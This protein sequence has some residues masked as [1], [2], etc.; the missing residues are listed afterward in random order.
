M[1]ELSTVPTAIQTELPPAPE[2]EPTLQEL[3]DTFHA[4]QNNEPVDR[5]V[6]TT[7]GQKLDAYAEYAT[8]EQ[9]NRAVKRYRGPAKRDEQ[10]NVILDEAGNEVRTNIPQIYAKLIRNAAGAAENG[11]TTQEDWAKAALGNDIQ[12]INLSQART[13][14]RA[15]IVEQAFKA[16]EMHVADANEK[17]EVNA[18]DKTDITEEQHGRT[19]TEQ[20][21][22][23]ALG[24]IKGTSPSPEKLSAAIGNLSDKEKQT[25][26]KKL[27]SELE[28]QINVGGQT[29]FNKAVSSAKAIDE[30]L[31]A[32]ASRFVPPNVRKLYVNAALKVIDSLGM[33]GQIIL[34]NSTS[35][36]LRTNRE[37]AARNIER[38]SNTTSTD[39]EHERASRTLQLRRIGKVAAANAVAVPTR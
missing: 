37:Q 6:L 31:A 25:V 12:N 8:D 34:Q 3:R 18:E 22:D 32:H 20:P 19:E 2:P 4:L 1:S 11:A 38:L 14:I 5:A 33:N 15:L 13:F 36:L 9:G 7:L 27:S 35:Q 17:P 39:A 23:K 21:L 30:Y 16:K 10:G 29:D 28:E 24:L 26:E